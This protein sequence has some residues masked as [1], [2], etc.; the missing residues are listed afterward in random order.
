MKSIKHKISLFTG[1]ACLV[2]IVVMTMFSVFSSNHLQQQTNMQ[3]QA[4]LMEMFEKELKAELSSASNA[5]ENVFSASFSEVSTLATSF[6]EQKKLAEQTPEL[7]Q[8]LRA[9]L[10]KQLAGYLKTKPDILGSYTLWEPNALDGLDKDFRNATGS[11]SDGRFV[12]YWTHSSTGLNINTGEGFE[13]QSRPDGG[14][15]V[16]EY[17]LCSK[18]SHK[19]C[20]TNP[21]FYPVNGKDTLITSIVSPV[22]IGGDFLGITGI[23]VS[24]EA[25]NNIIIALG[26]KLYH[27]QNKVLL[28]TSSGTVVAN[29]EGQHL[30]KNINKVE[31]LSNLRSELSNH[32]FKILTDENEQTITA[33]IPV[34]I[35]KDVAP[36]LLSISLE[37]ALVLK[38]IVD[39]QQ[40]AAD[41]QVQQTWLSL[42][43][44]L[45]ILALCIAI[46]WYIAS[47]ISAPIQQ[48]ANF[49][50]KVAEGDFSDRLTKNLKNPDET[51]ELARA[52]NTFLEKTQEV[53]REVKTASQQLSTNA[54]ESAASSSQAQQGINQQQQMISQASVAATEMSTTAQDVAKHAINASAATNSTQQATENS[55][56]VLGDVQQSIEK[57]NAEVEEATA[58]ITRLGENSQNIYSIMDVI[59]SIADQTNLLALN[60]AIEAA[61]AGEH[62]R[63]FAVV[64]D[65][66]RSLSLR[67][68]TSTEEIYELISHLQQD[69]QSAVGVMKSGSESALQCVE[70]A[71]NATEQLTQVT[72][73]VDQITQLNTEVASA[74]EQQSVVA[75]QINVNLVNL[76][77]LANE[78]T[79]SAEQANQGSQQLQATS[80]GLN[81]MVAHFKA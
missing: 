50:L 42:M 80:Q 70:L 35:D 37:K 72:H 22:L 11:N 79:E 69:A 60:A 76:T 14:D 67:T 34:N 54:L 74:A 40:K 39:L 9:T 68:Q 33:L 26:R 55:Q 19:N 44:G 62:G 66:V 57:L 29:S 36:W 10:N 59:K 47:H 56:Q 24:V 21:Y 1:A 20:V 18:D 7:K 52:C 25:L 46:I 32:Q 48:I 15:R 73:E 31:S 71:H 8:T 78:L 45:V 64:A 63:G 58:V 49:M 51:G 23:D 77:Q 4:L 6:I 43:V 30:G 5:I 16:G 38:D 41:E 65:E 28:L 81:D 75:E 12:P 3:S 13:D 2:A 61:R 53:I 17:Y 27:G